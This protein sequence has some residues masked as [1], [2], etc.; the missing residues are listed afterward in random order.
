M[1]ADRNISPSAHELQFWIPL[2]ATSVYRC[3]RQMNMFC[4]QLW[5]VRPWRA[6]STGLVRWET[7][8]LWGW[9]LMPVLLRHAPSRQI[10]D[11]LTNTSSAF[12]RSSQWWV[13][14]LCVPVAASVGALANFL[15]WEIL[16]LYIL[17][18]DGLSPNDIWNHKR[19]LTSVADIIPVEP[20]PLLIPKHKW[21]ESVNKSKNLPLEGKWKTDVRPRKSLFSFW[22]MGITNEM[23]S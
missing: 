6:K 14:T 3:Y 13:E 11:G 12:P 5:V 1:S 4:F 16:C 8:P 22:F 20:I 7:Y 23:L 17:S 19:I 9:T 2:W 10:A 21:R 18:S 15:L